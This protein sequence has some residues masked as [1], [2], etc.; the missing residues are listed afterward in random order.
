MMPQLR[1][2]GMA[3]HA[4]ALF[5]KFWP[6]GVIAALLWTVALWT[7][8]DADAQAPLPPLGPPG[9]ENVWVCVP[10][11]DGALKCKFVLVCK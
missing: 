7:V 11:P 8:C 9:C 10:G 4:G 2:S 5:D 1:K 3:D 6:A